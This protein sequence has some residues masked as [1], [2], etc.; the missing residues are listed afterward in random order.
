LALVLSFGCIITTH[1]LILVY[2]GK[3]SVSNNKSLSLLKLN[4]IFTNIFIILQFINF[5]I[6]E[7]IKNDSN[8][9]KYIKKCNYQQVPVFF[10]IFN[11]V[12]FYNL[13]IYRLHFAYNNK[14]LILLSISISVLFI[15]F[16]IIYYYQINY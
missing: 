3:I 5:F 8:I 4:L 14:F 7:I 16:S 2:K 15:I 13:L 1:G 10:Y 6:P 9:N 12:F 11:H